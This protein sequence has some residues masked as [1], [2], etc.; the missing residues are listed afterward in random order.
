MRILI[1]SQWFQPEQVLKG[2][3]FIGELQAMGHEVEVLTGFPNYPGGKV[4]P[5]YR[6]KPFQ[7]ETLAGTRVNRVPLYPSHDKSGMKRFVTYASFALSASL[8]GPWVVKRPDVIYVYHPPGTIGLPAMV[9]KALKRAPVVY[10]IQDMWPD[11][12]G[13]SG[14]MSKG[15]FL[16]ILSAWMSLVYRKT[17]AIAVLSPGFKRLLV[18]RGVPAEK[19]E[20]IYNWHD[21]QSDSASEAPRD[22]PDQLGITGEFVVVFAG[23]MGVSQALDA[24]LDAAKICL[25]ANPA[26][27][28]VFVGGGIDRERLAAKAESEGLSNV[29]F[30]APQPITNMP[31]IF[32]RADALLV[33]LRNDP[34]FEITI[35]SK[36]Q[37][38][39]AAGRPIVM[40]VRGDARD[41]VESGG[42]GVGA[43]PENAEEV[44][45]AVL[46]LAAMPAEE[47]EAMG[48]RGREFYENELSLKIGAARFAALFER[49]R[50]K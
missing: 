33:H 25:A 35:P 42:A 26:V 18:E 29:Q 30:V 38:Y 20:V 46:R 6:I 3:P 37:A 21:D 31:V 5:G 34:L 48:R 43:A 41:L 27:R 49:V 28:F 44:A 16:K 11:T 32:D 50:R 9:L 19:V 1:L 8:I 36:T 13:S 47:R 45:A 22:L 23:T 12:I 15:S 14:M 24:V 2:V 10:D 7:R 40:G 4:Y 17:D 39:L